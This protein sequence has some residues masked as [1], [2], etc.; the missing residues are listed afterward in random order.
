MVRIRSF[1]PSDV[2][3]IDRIWR[4]HHSDDFSVPN[5]NTVITEAVIENEAGEVI[6]YGQVKMFAEAIMILDK[7][8]SQRDK[9]AALQKLLL[10]AFR[11]S[12]EFGLDKVNAFIKDP[13]FALVLERHFGFERATDPGEL[14]Y[15]EL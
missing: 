2:E 8:A 3:V 5:R 14:V 10:E 7:N 4:D 11:G 12:T 13:D 9:V 1:R 6:A 15:K